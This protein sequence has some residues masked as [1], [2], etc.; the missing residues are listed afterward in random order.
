[1]DAAPLDRLREFNRCLTS[2]DAAGVSLSL[3]AR[4]RGLQARIKQIES[5]L[6]VRTELGQSLTTAIEAEEELPADYRCAALILLASGDTSEAL[7]AVALPN[8]GVVGV[9]RSVTR[10]LVTPLILVAMIYGGLL[11]LCLYTTPRFAAVYA[12]IE[13]TPSVPLSV[14]LWLRA[15]LPVW[16]VLVPLFATAGVYAVLYTN[17]KR[18]LGWSPAMRGFSRA[19]RRAAVV[20]QLSRLSRNNVPLTAAAK[21]IEQRPTEVGWPADPPASPSRQ[22]GNRE[23]TPREQTTAR[24]E[25]P[26]LTWSLAGDASPQQ[27]I[28]R[29]AF[30]ANSYRQAARRRARYWAIAGPVLASG[31]VGGV[32]ML[33]YGW[34]LFAPF[35]ALVEDLAQPASCNEIQ[36]QPRVAHGATG[37]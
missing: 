19:S 37:R 24:R 3:D 17:P 26:L 30:A 29:L 13:Q 31:L 6:E 7:D 8:D 12:Q 35:A 1:M 4:G 10:L 15:W 14:L 5:R 36:L 18:L 32:L 27:R 21:L 11:L 22:A 2:L 20:E 28:A 33:G 9:K 16:A 34:A 23:V 25:S